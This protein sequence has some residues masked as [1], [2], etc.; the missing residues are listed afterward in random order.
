MRP[1]Y[2]LTWY[3]LAFHCPLG[4]WLFSLV[5]YSH[6]SSISW[7]AR[8]TRTSMVRVVYVVYWDDSPNSPEMGLSESGL[9]N[10]G[11]SSL[12]HYGW[13]RSRSRFGQ[14]LGQSVA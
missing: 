13:L 2:G 3:A 6:L 7:W 4:C 11:R 10:E 5:D 12:L 9:T 8:G 14:S 1:P